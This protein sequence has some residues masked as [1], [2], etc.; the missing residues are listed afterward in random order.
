MSKG[1]TPIFRLMVYHFPQHRP[2]IEKHRAWTKLLVAVDA[3]FEARR[4]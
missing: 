3:T 4:G 2:H 1:H